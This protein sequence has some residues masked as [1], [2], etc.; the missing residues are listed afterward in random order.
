[1]TNFS[2]VLVAVTVMGAAIGST[3]ASAAGAPGTT[4]VLVHGAWSN[5]SAWDRVIPHLEAAGLKV[6]SVNNALGSLKDDVANT[7]RVIDD[8]TGPVLLVGH[9]YGGM[10]ITEAGL[11]D[12]VK[13]LVY[14]AAFVPGPGQSTNAILSQFPAPAWFAS[15]HVDAKGYAYWPADAMGT[16][17]AAG[18]PKAEVRLL[19]ATQGPVKLSVNDDAVGDKVA[20]DGKPAWSVVSTED[21]IIPA[22]LQ[23]HFADVIKSKVINVKAGHLPMLV[24][25]KAVA[26]AIIKAAGS[27]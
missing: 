26:D 23:A 14:V 20:Y 25:P 10:V 19:A 8:Q 13:G 17:F 6:V 12:K 22:P 21:Q 3:A 1:M 5:S 18:L 2:K 16:Y 9:S 7:L 27:I 4:V 11:D 24:A 15:L